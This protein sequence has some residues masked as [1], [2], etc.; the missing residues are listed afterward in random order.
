MDSEAW[1]QQKGPDPPGG[2]VVEADGPLRH[3]DSEKKGKIGEL[4]GGG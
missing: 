2:R 3:R 4:R 1:R